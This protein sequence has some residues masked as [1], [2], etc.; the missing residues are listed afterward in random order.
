MTDQTFGQK[1]VGLSFNPSKDD[2]VA[3]IKQ[4]Y[5]TIIDMLDELRTENPYGKEQARLASIA[6]TQAQDAQMWAVKAI[7]WRE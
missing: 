3:E 6:I 1:A 7:T 2:A 4:R 5:A